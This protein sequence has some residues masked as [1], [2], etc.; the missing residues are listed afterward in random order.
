LGFSRRESLHYLQ[1]Q[2]EPAL[3]RWKSLTILVPAKT[4]QT[5]KDLIYHASVRTDGVS[6]SFFNSESAT[7]FTLTI[8]DLQPE[9]F[10]LY[11]YLQTMKGPSTVIEF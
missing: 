2:S 7:E 6:T 11:H 1:G 8:E 4:R 10:A 5:F 3:H 9:D